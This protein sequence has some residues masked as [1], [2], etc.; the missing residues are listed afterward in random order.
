M[1]QVGSFSGLSIDKIHMQDF[2]MP[3][4]IGMQPIQSEAQPQFN[5]QNDV[6]LKENPYKVNIVT[7]RLAKQKTAENIN[8]LNRITGGTFNS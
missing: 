8:F 6:Q 5:T 2:Q 3:D 7:S 1:D 4:E